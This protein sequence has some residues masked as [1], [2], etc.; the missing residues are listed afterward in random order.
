MKR[1]SFRTAQLSVKLDE[2]LFSTLKDFSRKERCTPFMVLL[3]ALEVMLHLRTG[4]TDIRV[5]TLVA[6]RDRPETERVIG[7]FINTVILRNRVRRNMTLRELLTQVRATTLG[8][9]AHQHL[10]F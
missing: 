5:G 3:G 7:H 9:C 10:P 8:A 2:N 4:Q 1:L 6:N